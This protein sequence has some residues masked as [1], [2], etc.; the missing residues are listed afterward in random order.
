[1]LLV[2]PNCRIFCSCNPGTAEADVL[3][4]QKVGSFC[5]D[6]GSVLDAGAAAG[7]VDGVHEV[8]LVTPNCE[9]QKT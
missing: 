2:G 7:T 6:V 1:M 5:H 8:F 3:F 4:G 9:T